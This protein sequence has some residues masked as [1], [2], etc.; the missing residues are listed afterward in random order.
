VTISAL[1]SATISYAGSPYCGNGGTANVTHTGTTGG[2][3]TSTAGL[4]INPATGAINIASSTPGTY[5]V[6]YSI[7]ATGPCAAFSTTTDVTITT[8]PVA[9]ISYTGSPYCSN[10]GVVS[11]TATGASGGTYTSTTGLTI[12]PATGAI[13][14]ATSAAGNYIVTYTINGAGGCGTYTTTTNVII[15]TAPSATIAYAGSPYCGSTGLAVVTQ[16]G[17]PGGAFSSSTGLVINP[18]TGVINLA[19]S[20]PGTYTVTYTIAAAN[21][22][23]AYTATTVVQLTTPGT[24]TGLAGTDWNNAS[25]WC[26]GIPSSATDAIIPAAA[27]NMPNIS[28][29]AGAARNV[30]LEQGVV[31]TVGTAGTLELHG[32]MT[33]GGT[34]DAA[35]GSIILRGITDQ[36]MP[37]FT[38]TNLTMNM[39]GAGSL[40]LGGNSTVTGTLTM[41]NGNITLGPN[42][43]TMSGSANGKLTSHIITNGSGSVIVRNLASSQSRTIPVGSDAVSYN[44]VALTTNAGHVPDDFTIRVQQGVYENGT[45][46][47]TFQTHVADRMWLI[48]ES[49][50]GGSNMDITLQW[51]GSQELPSF[52]RAKSYVTQYGGTGWLVGAPTSS[53]GGDPYAQTKTGVTTLGSFAVQTE[54][55]P[56]PLTGIYPNPASDHINVVTDLLSTGP[57]VFSVYDDHGKLVYRKHESLTVGLNQTRLDIAHLSAGVYILKVSTRLNEQFIVQR[58]VK[59]N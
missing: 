31:L 44:P 1:P 59:T 54:P 57:V 47:N 3:Y 8:P 27:V 33:G 13:N 9:T 6:T 56:R 4:T 22:C 29:G 5:T 50:A 14:T 15:S 16:G 51:S 7:D 20:T 55:I 11:V 45:S 42:N 26:G 23:G 24:W 32:N 19:T 36:A 49:V 28:N 52:N 18:A 17:T 10:A 2:A 53:L 12:D 30:V 48:N 38:A 41:A 35:N 25:N 21:G 34:L 37:A 43:F 46:G 58:F 39:V 40:I